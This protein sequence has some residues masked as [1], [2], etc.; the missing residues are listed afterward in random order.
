[1]CMCVRLAGSYQGLA[2]PDD[3][4]GGGGGG[5]EAQKAKRE[6]YRAEFGHT[7]KHTPRLVHTKLK[8]DEQGL[9]PPNH[10]WE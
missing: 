5:G 9:R 4:Y 2:L 7:S 3:R 10:I 1:M 8:D 6:K